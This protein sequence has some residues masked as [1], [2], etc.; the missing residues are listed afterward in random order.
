MAINRVYLYA[1]SSVLYSPLSSSIASAASAFKSSL[2]PSTVPV[3]VRHCERSE[4]I[5]WDAG[6]VALSGLLRRFAPRNDG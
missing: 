4:A 3:P 5:P 2:K 6:N 1:P